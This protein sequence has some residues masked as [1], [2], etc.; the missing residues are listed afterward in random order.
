MNSTVLAL[1]TL[2]LCLSACTAV[3]SPAMVL[4]TQ[5]VVPSAT[6]SPRII[7]SATQIP[8]PRLT[9]TPRRP[10]IPTITLIP[11]STNTP[12]QLLLSVM[13]LQTT[14][15]LWVYYEPE[16]KFLIIDM[17]TG[18]IKS[19]PSPPNCL[20]PTFDNT[21]VICR[22][23][24]NLYL[25]DLATHDKKDLPITN[26]DRLYLLPW[27]QNSRFLVYGYWSDEEERLV[28]IYSFDLETKQ[29]KLLAE[30]MPDGEYYISSDGRHV[31]TEIDNRIVD[32]MSNP[33]VDLT[34]VGYENLIY[35]TYSLIWSPIS[36]LLYIGATDT[37]SDAFPL[38]NNYFIANVDAGIVTKISVPTDVLRNA[39]LGAYWSP[40]GNQIAIADGPELCN[41]H[42]DELHG[43]CTDNIQ[44]P[45]SSVSSIAWSP[46]SRFIAFFVSDTIYIYDTETKRYFSLLDNIFT[47]EIFWR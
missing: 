19:T 10:Y 16:S 41:Y 44:E 20:Y 21:E 40:D 32:I 8:Q 12:Y 18:V 39:I 33:E 25:Y 14:D 1:V 2:V 47:T 26:P 45:G 29:E 15:E 4:P 34:P 37:S 27:V 46:D 17:V 31:I 38:T 11:T 30:N 35:N 43:E 24:G 42:I 7:P 6:V 36:N 28:D 23:S 5:T 3:P 9:S 13:D 22:G